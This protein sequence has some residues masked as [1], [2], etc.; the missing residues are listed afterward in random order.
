MQ[1]KQLICLNF[2]EKYGTLDE[3]IKNLKYKQ[4]NIEKYKQVLHQLKNDGFIDIEFFPG[5]DGNQ[6][7]TGPCLYRPII[8]LQKGIELKEKLENKNKENFKI[9]MIVVMNILLVVCAILQTIK[10]FI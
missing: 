7:L 2:I 5:A 8:L 3:K 9:V 6:N 10:L 4:F 1:N